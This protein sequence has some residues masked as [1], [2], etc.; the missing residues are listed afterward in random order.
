MPDDF[1]SAPSR[2]ISHV[3]GQQ[4]GPPLTSPQK[5]FWKLDVFSV[6]PPLEKLQ[7]E[8]LQENL[9]A[10]A[11]VVSPK[12]ETSASAH[13]FASEAASISVASKDLLSAMRN[14]F[15]GDIEAAVRRLDRS[16]KI[17]G[18]VNRSILD[19]VVLDRHLP[20]IVQ[21]SLD[22]AI[23]DTEAS[24]GHAEAREVGGAAKKLHEAHCH[25]ENILSMLV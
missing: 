11:P 24:L 10:N 17:L 19:E 7:G 23:R 25:L 1:S 16:L 22:K 13:D 18:E 15:S 8:K 12:S 3:K 4:E 20:M 6:Q 5:D 2:G 14:I 21:E 9:S